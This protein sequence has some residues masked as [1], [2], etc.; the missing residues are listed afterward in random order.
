MFSRTIT[1][2][3]WLSL[4][5]VFFI[6]NIL[7]WSYLFFRLGYHWFITSII[8]FC[9]FFFPFFYFM[10]NFN[11]LFLPK[12]IRILLF[13][14]ADILIFPVILFLNLRLILRFMALDTLSIVR[15]NLLFFFFYY[16]FA[17]WN[18]NQKVFIH[19][20]FIALITFL[21]PWFTLLKMNIK[22]RCWYFKFAILAE[23]GFFITIF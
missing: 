1:F 12:R 18:M 21:R 14:R 15:Y 8:G 10:I 2:L 6:Y 11:L 9:L 16:S 7:T 4:W 13:L 3:D 17:C 20:R 23:F 19:D 5:S 22:P